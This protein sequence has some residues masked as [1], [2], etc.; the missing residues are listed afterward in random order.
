MVGPTA[1]P[2]HMICPVT[3]WSVEA[4]ARPCPACSQDHPH[5]GE[6]HRRSQDAQIKEMDLR[7][8][9]DSHSPQLRDVADAFGSDALV[10]VCRTCAYRRWLSDGYRPHRCDPES[11]SDHRRRQHHLDQLMLAALLASLAAVGVLAVLR[12][13]DEL[14]RSTDASDGSMYGLALAVPLLML[15]VTTYWQIPRKRILQRIGVPSKGRVVD[16]KTGWGNAYS[17]GKPY[18][19]VKY[20]TPYGETQ[21]CRVQGT[22]PV[23]V[24]LLVDPVA[25]RRA[26]AVSRVEISSIEL[27]MFTSAIAM[28]FVAIL[29]F[30]L[31]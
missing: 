4:R 20:T 10:M 24:E 6:E 16:V 22:H 7:F 25:P 18:S 19:I 21:S 13:V 15:A 14:Q 26:S 12:G 3:G 29:A 31:G 5:P 17:S 30:M 11:P 27:L 28:Y 1:D 2:G 8:R 9:M 23:D